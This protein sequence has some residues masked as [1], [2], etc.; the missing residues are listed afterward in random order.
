MNHDPV[1]ERPTK[2][3]VG[4]TAT[5]PTGSNE[6]FVAE[7]VAGSLPTAA[8]KI[9]RVGLVSRSCAST[10]AF[11]GRSDIFGLDTVWNLVL[12]RG[13]NLDSPL[14]PHLQVVVAREGVHYLE[15]VSELP[16]ID[17][18]IL[19]K[20]QPPGMAHPFWTAECGPKGRRTETVPSSW[21]QLTPIVDH[22]R[23]GGVT[24]CR[25]RLT[26]MFRGPGD[27]LPDG[28]AWLS[29]SPLVTNHF[30]DLVDVT[31]RGPSCPAPTGRGESLLSLDLG[32]APLP[33]TIATG[34]HKGSS[35]LAL[36]SVFSS[37]GFVSRRL[38]PHERL[39]ALDVPATLLI[40]L[41]RQRLIAIAESMS[42]PLKIVNW[43]GQRLGQLVRTWPFQGNEPS[44]STRKRPSNLNNVRSTKRHRSA[45]TPQPN[46]YGPLAGP[47]GDPRRPTA[48]DTRIRFTSYVP[49]RGD[50]GSNT[51]AAKGDDAQIPT[52]LFNDRLAFL[53]GQTTLTDRQVELLHPL[54]RWMWKEWFRRVR[55]S[56]WR[57]WR[58]N[59]SLLAQ[60]L[61]STTVQRVGQSGCYAVAYA[62]RSSFWAW[63]HG[64]AP[65]FW[66]WRKE[67]QLDLA[68]GHAPRWIKDDRPHTMDPQ[69]GLGSEDDRR[70]LRDKIAK[71]RS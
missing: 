42:V 59:K 28:K 13:G 7:A 47:L 61:T 24:D 50:L 56:W 8:P 3:S 68:L 32:S 44:K 2:H 34:S 9:A 60:E 36:P 66:R 70:L 17:I 71:F 41:D 27:C 26:V 25:T 65:F 45:S 4:G 49:P 69:R 6:Q 12:E 55:S 22:S 10:W 19:D 35:L 15:L 21:V 18:L 58:E 29:V 38:T 39:L 54:R 23:L 5:A 48:L 57:W 16:P 52:F 11:L 20:V 67:Y 63:D 33:L 64:S 1:V 31:Q 62:S 53:L 46:W 37:T 14:A 51:K 43:V 40:G 30:L